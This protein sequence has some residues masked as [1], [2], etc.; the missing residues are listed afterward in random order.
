[1]NKRNMQYFEKPRKEIAFSYFIFFIISY[2]TI[3]KPKG[4]SYSI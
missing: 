2:K 1:M 4:H 3:Y